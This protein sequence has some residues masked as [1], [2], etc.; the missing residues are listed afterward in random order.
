MSYITQTT[1][2]P[3][4]PEVIWSKPETKALAGKL[5]IVG[6]NMH[7]ISAPS[8]AYIAANKAGA[9]EVR[10]VLPDA[11]KRYFAHQHIPADIMFAP[12]TPSGSFSAE[13]LQPLMEYSNWA[14]YVC[15]VG[16]ISKNSETAVI[17]ASF[18]R[19]LSTALC[20]TGDTI[21]TL[22]ENAAELLL[23]PHTLVVP[24]FAQLQKYSQQSKMTTALTTTLPFQAH[25]AWLEEFGRT[26]AAAVIYKLQNSAYVAYDGNVS[27]TTTIQQR[28]HWELHTAVTAAVWIMQQPQQSFKAMTTSLVYQ[29][30]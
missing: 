29:N 10:V 6:G 21:D 13:A 28:A 8:T 5:L 1:T 12:S 11:T 17:I 30:T 2:T 19:E 25:V 22:Q 15:I 27:V 7:S 23:R 4:Y 26:N 24:T 20:I 16:D 18:I 14:D 3:A 9:G